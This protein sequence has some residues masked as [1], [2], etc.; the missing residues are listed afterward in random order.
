MTMSSW[1][2]VSFTSC[3]SSMEAMGPRCSYRRTCC[4]TQGGGN[5]TEHIVK[6]VSAMGPGCHPAAPTA[7]THQALW[8]WQCS[9]PHTQ[10]PT[11][12]ALLV[13]RAL[14]GQAQLVEAIA[15]HVLLVQQLLYREGA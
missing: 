6:L 5:T 12:R 8:V 13:Q 9:P 15:H 11:H 10:P 1:P 4:Y 14:A 2:R 3:S 7:F